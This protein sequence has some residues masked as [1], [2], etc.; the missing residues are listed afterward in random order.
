MRLYQR[1]LE[2]RAT[3]FMGGGSTCLSGRTMAYRTQLF[4]FDGFK[5]YFLN[6]HFAGQ[7]QLSGD[8][9]CLTRLCIMSDYKMCHQICEVSMREAFLFKR[10]WANKNNAKGLLACTNPFKTSRNRGPY[11]RIG[12]CISHSHTMTLSHCHTPL[13]QFPVVDISTAVGIVSAQKTVGVGKLSA[14]AFARRIVRCWH[15]LGYR[16]IDLG[17]TPQ[18]CV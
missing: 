2:Y 3:T 6:E 18:G 4:R 16:A 8:D 12:R 7:L 5:N 14:R 9:K 13:G 1:Y 17:K 10:L 11:Y 15:G